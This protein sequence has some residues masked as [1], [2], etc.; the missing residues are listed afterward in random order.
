MHQHG[1]GDRNRTGWSA[2]GRG[3]FWLL[4]VGGGCSARYCMYL[5]KYTALGLST[6]PLREDNRSRLL[7]ASLLLSGSVSQSVQASFGP[8]RGNRRTQVAGSKARPAPRLSPLQ[9]GLF[10]H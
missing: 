7:R 3:S 6:D 2:W 5:A 4:E 9:R 8:L 1:G 10:Q